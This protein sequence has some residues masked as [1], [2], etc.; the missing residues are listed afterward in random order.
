MLNWLL[1]HTKELPMQSK[2]KLYV[3]ITRAIY[4]VGIVF[5]NK[6]NIEIEG[7]YQYRPD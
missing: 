3:A 2:A 1:D 6:K 5:N 4:S 7:I